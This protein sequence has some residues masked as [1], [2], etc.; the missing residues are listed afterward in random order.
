MENP[1]FQALEPIFDTHPQK[2]P[3]MTSPFAML[4]GFLPLSIC[5]FWASAERS[6]GQRESLMRFCAR[7]TCIY[8]LVV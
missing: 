3:K 1:S 5:P 7:E 8:A 6:H 4:L 2:T